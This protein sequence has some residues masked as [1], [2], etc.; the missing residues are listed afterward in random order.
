M[1]LVQFSAG[2]PTF[3]GRTSVVPAR[4]IASLDPGAPFALRLADGT[5]MPQCHKPPSID[6]AYLDL[7]LYKNAAKDP[8][9]VSFLSLLTGKEV[10]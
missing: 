9:S 5:V 8:N 6:N 2:L 3:N 4:R 10:T 7:D 1:C